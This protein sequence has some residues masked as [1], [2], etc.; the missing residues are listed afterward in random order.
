MRRL[1]VLVFGA[2]L[3][4]L[5]T[6]RADENDVC[7]SA[8]VDGQKLQK[9]GKLL[10]A[11]ARFVTCAS[12]TC[13]AEIVQ[14]CTRW[15]S[16]VDQ[17]TPSVALAARDA[18]GHEL[19]DVLVSI[20]GAAPATTGSRAIPLDPGIHTFTFKRP[21][22]G[23]VIQQATLHEGEKN[24]EIVATYWPPPG[25]LAM[26]RASSRPIPATVWIAAGVSTAG[27]A[28]FGTFGALGV[29][30]RSVDRCATGCS[31]SQNSDVQTKFD[32]A[33]VSLGIGVAALGVA[34]W[35]FFARPPV[36]SRGAA[37]VALIP[38]PGGGFATLGTRW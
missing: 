12:Q 23:D 14:D 10:D 22:R 19:T 4:P 36:D 26:P 11:H 21:G 32:V 8:P 9:A 5:R 20:D 24:R 13:P 37:R 35:Q 30:A 17:A 25:T 31:P 38:V 33:D 18:E 1:F 27:F 34:A 29:G 2:T 15:A 16:E 6:A 3:L 28:L 7:L